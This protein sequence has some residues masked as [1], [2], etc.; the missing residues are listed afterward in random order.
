MLK[1]GA[2]QYVEFKKVDGTFVCGGDGKLSSVPDSRSAIFKDSSLGLAEKN[3]LGSFF[4]LVEGHLKEVGSDGGSRRISEEDLE[5]PFVEFLDKMRLP[6]KIK[7]IIIYAIAMADYDQDN[8]EGCKNVLKTREGINRLALYHSSVGRFHNALGALIYPIYGQG[9]LSQAFCRR[10]AVKGCL[11]VLRMPVKALLMDKE[12]GSCKGAKVASGQDLFSNEIVLGPSFMTPLPLANSLPDFLRAKLEDIGQDVTGK[13]AR[14]IC[15][16]NSSLK[17]DVSTCLVVYPPQSLY[18][19]QVT[20]IRVLQI[21]SSLVVCPSGMFV[22]YLST[23]CDDAIHGKKSLHAAINTIFSV[24]TSETP[25]NSS[26]DKSEDG[27]VKPN[28]LWSALYIQELFMGSF[29]PFCFT[30]MPDGSLNYNDLLDSTKELFHKM[31]PQ[32]EFFPETVFSQLDDD[33]ELGPSP[34]DDSLDS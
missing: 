15:I 12:S 4:K 34:S 17:T 13:V 32:E 16:T 14:A 2:N 9:E 10:A 28:L 26:Y 29:D 19:E 31:F 7:S 1:S 6:V 5:R 23:L 22:V 25:E 18:P 8:L 3:R 11:Y 30:P 20:S 24:A 21:G 27:E 33:S